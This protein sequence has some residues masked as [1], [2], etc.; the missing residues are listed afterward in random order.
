MNKLRVFV[1]TN[2]VC[3]GNGMMLSS[4][5]VSHQPSVYLSPPPEAVS[6]LSVSILSRVEQYGGNLL[7]NINIFS[8]SEINNKLTLML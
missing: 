2:V 3:D 1:L 7:Q 6:Q 5:S 4:V 8:L